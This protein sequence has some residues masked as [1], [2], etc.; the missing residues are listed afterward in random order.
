AT[1][2]GA[3]TFPD[4][5]G[6]AAALRE[7]TQAGVRPTVI[8]LS[9]ER[10]TS[11]NAAMGGHLTRLRGC[12]AVATAEAATAAEADAVIAAVDA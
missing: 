7:L 2:Y 9:D 5:A 11:V 1:A 3:W 10:E 6:G 8:R 12:L 4:F